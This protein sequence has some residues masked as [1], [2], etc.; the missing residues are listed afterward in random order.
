MSE[1]PEVK[2]RLTAED[3]G[4]SAAIRQ[5]GQELKT[6]KVREQEAAEGAFSLTRAFEGLVAIGGV[7]KLE[8]IGR[9]A[10]NAAVDISKM[11]DKTGLS[12]ETL[13]VFHKVAEDVGAST[14]GVDKGLI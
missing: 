5:L 8:E 13:S 2:V 3:T 9:E 7:L 11:S 12:T 14:E 10:F 1:T 6:L 4:V